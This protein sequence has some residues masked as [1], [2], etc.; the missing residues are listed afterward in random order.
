MSSFNKILSATMT[1]KESSL[2]HV[3]TLKY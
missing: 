2:M 1:F 3:Y